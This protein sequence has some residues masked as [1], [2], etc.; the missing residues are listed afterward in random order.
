MARSGSP[1]VGVRMIDV[2]LVLIALAAGVA[3]GYARG[4]RL[5]KLGIHPPVRNRLILTALGVYAAGVL[6]GW[7][8]DPLL[9]VM[10]GLCWLVLGFYAWVNRGRHGARLL[11]LGLAA[12][13]LVILVNGAMPVS[14]SVE[15]RAGVTQ[16][17][18]AD[19]GA[20]AMTEDTV[21]PWLGK[22]IPVAF[23]PRPEVVSPGD[24]AVAAGCAAALATGMTGRWQPA[25]RGVPAAR[26]GAAAVTGRASR[27][28]RATMD[29]DVTAE[30]VPQSP[31]A[32]A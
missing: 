19:D 9:P 14:I 24:V 32:T 8:W 28:A 17:A 15:A 7:A 10:S 23:P 5:R 18:S 2:V 11:A 26:R 1:P 12:N 6:G 22:V 30:P 16:T 13:G 29:D 25:G 21:L 31:R 4:G 20:T 3:A 27:P